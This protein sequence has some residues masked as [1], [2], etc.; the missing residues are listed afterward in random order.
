MLTLVYKDFLLQRGGKSIVYMFIMPVISAFAL[1]TEILFV[2]MP[3]IAGSYLYIVYANALD[4]KYNTEKSLL[5]MPIKRSQIVIAKYLGI[6]FY[7]TAFYMVVLILSISFVLIIPSY[8]STALM[9][10]G[11]LVQF[12][13]VGSLY[14]SVFFPIYFK[15]GYQK[16]RWANYIS[17]VASLGLLT[18]ATRGL[19]LMTNIEITS[20]QAGLEYLT[21]I[22]SNTWV[23][24]LPIISG[25]IV[26]L[27][28]K[29]S[30][31]FYSQRE[32]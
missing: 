8:S 25:I 26:F 3:F 17:M 23:I 12:I 32:F 27:S 14:Y 6:L 7:L 21:G 11:H 31:K 24:L 2:I 19:S 18:A 28:L 1:S 13:T 29:L 30:I 15:L 22:S 5:S 20:L 4:D 16:S 10:L 9:G